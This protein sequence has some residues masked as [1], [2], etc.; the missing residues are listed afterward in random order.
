[1]INFW[2]FLFTFIL[3]CLPFI[4]LYYFCRNANAATNTLNMLQSG[5]NTID[6]MKRVVYICK[7]IAEQ[8]K[9]AL[10]DLDYVQNHCEDLKYIVLENTAEKK[11][12]DENE[13][14]IYR[15]FAEK[16]LTKLSE[17]F[18]KIADKCQLVSEKINLKKEDIEFFNQFSN[19]SD[20]NIV[21][22]FI[23]KQVLEGCEDLM[24]VK[25]YIEKGEANK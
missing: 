9:I 6:L 3:I 18:N 1:M 24:F 22:W 19:M 15:I 12:L 11:Q 2:I 21:E 13:E 10:K 20:K 16:R 17:E 14:R 25:K 5:R 23:S 4:L 8:S 7:H